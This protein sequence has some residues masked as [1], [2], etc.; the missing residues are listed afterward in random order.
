MVLLNHLSPS[1]SFMPHG[2]CYLWNPGL[3][4]LHV[5][6]DGLIALAYLSIPV[7]LLYFARKKRGL[8]FNW[9]FVC[10]GVFIVACGGTHILEIWNLWHANYWIAGV[11]KAITAV[12]SVVTAVLSVRLVPQALALP[13]H[14]DLWLANDLRISLADRLSLATEVARLGV[15]EWDL[16][17]KRATWNATMFEIYGLEPV[18]PVRYEKWIAS[19]LPEDLPALETR[20]QK[21]SREKCESAQQFRIRLPNGSVRDISAV[22]RVF[23][24]SRGE[25]ARMIGVNWDITESKRA[26]EALRASE[27]QFRHLAETIREVFFIQTTDPIRTEYIS[28]AYDE[29]WGRSRQELYDRP[30]V[31]IESVVAED[32][33]VAS[34]A[35][36]ECMQGRPTD[37]EFRVMRPDDTIRWIHARAFPVF[38]SKGKFIRAVGIAEDITERRRVLIEL[39]AARES[40]EAASRVK[41]EFLANMSHELRTPLNGIMGMTELA[42]DTDLTAE[43]RE[44][45]SMVKTSSDSLL[46]VINDILDFSKI[47]AGKL[48]FE[49]NEFNIRSGIEATM[50]ALAI[51]AHEKKIELN[52]R[53]RPEV[54]AVLVGDPSRL[55]Q[56]MVNL[57]GNAIKFTERGEVT[58]DVQEESAEAGSVLLHFSVADSGIGIPLEKQA[59]I[60][61]AFT[62][63]DGSTARRYGGSGLGLTISRRLVELF[64][65]RLWL[66]SAPGR[67]STFHFT[68]RFADAADSGELRP[69]EVAN[70][71]GVP[72]LVVDDN[73]TNRLILEEMLTG[74]RVN[75]T[76]VGDAA[77]GLEQIKSAA[78]AGHPFRVVL[79][80]AAMLEPGGFTTVEQITKDGRFAAE[81]VVMMISVGHRGDAAR[82]GG[83]GVA[84]YL[85][86]PVGQA[87][88]L[89]A[90]FRVLDG[91]TQRGAPSPL[92]THSLQESK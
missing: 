50:K 3:V 35:F 29:I 91:S 36:A 52:C 30:A 31:W 66:E 18:N 87:E 82:S 1:D 85:T 71:Q 56:I 90:I 83:L 79:A 43:Q 14:K 49:S 51:R 46:T 80:D 75:S 24:D 61:D 38:D 76:L 54:P 72:V 81:K 40:A 13:S 65:G 59:T 7:T 41:G 86:K 16:V 15:W 44:Y 17:A 2:Y 20:L 78:D 77:E 34:R 33:E 4:W 42:L 37:T 84:A 27:E 89:D 19:I 25:P 55:R 22:E 32:R 64:G 69:P 21:L 70:L 73:A 63:A 58:L 57:V 26:G 28:P 68:A 39:Q 10:F 23:V 92:V 9:I 67:G 60:F 6:S 12:A 48:D 53:V 11:L 62:Q 5:I 47:E 45:L 88:L 8:P 74:W